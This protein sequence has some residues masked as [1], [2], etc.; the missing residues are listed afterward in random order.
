MNIYKDGRVYLRFIKIMSTKKSTLLLG[1]LLIASMVFTGYQFWRNNISEQENI[2]KIGFITDAHFNADKNKK[3]GEYKL[4]WRSREALERFVEKMNKEFKPD[5]VIENGDFIDGKDKRSRKTW[6]EANELFKKIKAPGY[7]VLGNHETNSFKKDVW[8]R[9]VGYDK[10]YYFKDF[11]KGNAKYRIVVLDGNFLP[12][13][14]DTEPDKHYYS[15]HINGE[16]WQWLET[17][18]GDAQKQDRNVI[19][20]VHQPPLST[21]FFL[22][23]GVFPQGQELHRLFTKYNVRASFSG[24]IENLCNVKDG[25]T[26][27]FVLQ[28]FWK[29]K[30]YLKEEYRFKDAGAFYYITVAPSG[31]VEVEMEHRIFDDKIKKGNHLDKLKGW[32]NLSVT[33][34]YNCQDGVQ[35][36]Q[37][38]FEK[39]AKKSKMSRLPI[40]FLASSFKELSGLT[41]LDEYT[42]LVSDNGAIIKMKD[43][44]VI[45]QRDGIIPDA[46]GITNDG[47]FLYVVSELENA[48]YKFNKELKFQ[49]KK[50]LN[51]E[52]DGDVNVGLEG[53]AYYKDNLFFV[54]HQGKNIKSNIFVIDFKTGKIIKE[55]KI[56]QTDLA[57][58][59]VYK[60]KLCVVSAAS[61]KILWLDKDNLEIVSTED[62]DDKNVEGIDVKDDKIFLIK[63][64]EDSLRKSGNL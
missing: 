18:L 19:V 54:V 47:K 7:H 39:Q 31:E 58:A 56:E 20:F 9:L 11:N 14:S 10:T 60:D 15:G 24:H 4:H 61:Q 21:D 1:G 40:T 55:H 12:D 6:L 2:L 34:K 33:D 49:E 53:I 46:E 17:T 62:I 59:S 44:S 36:N 51:I 42:Y 28:G 29:G 5:L 43:E 45:K 52:H 57:G 48:I 32:F 27:Y 64:N 38:F 37:E 41:F 25:N 26:R 23:W 30:K 3:T 8:L 35:L 16:Q 22:N 50:K 63:D 13:N